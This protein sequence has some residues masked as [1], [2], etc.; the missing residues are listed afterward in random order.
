M[1]SGSIPKYDENGYNNEV[2]VS[3]KIATDLG[4]KVK[5]SIVAIFSKEASK[6]VYR[7]FEVAG[8][9]KTDINSIDDLL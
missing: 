3:G 2:I 4:L 8:I 5:D 1:I 9:Y 6:P 7:K